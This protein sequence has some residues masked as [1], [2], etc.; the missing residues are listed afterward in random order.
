MQHA[1]SVS[2]VRARTSL[3]IWAANPAVALDLDQTL[4]DS[5]SRVRYKTGSDGSARLSPAA[6]LAIRSR[7]RWRSRISA[8][9]HDRQ[10]P[11][12]TAHVNTHACPQCSR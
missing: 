3:G 4:A 5:P 9:R 2:H 6:S 7:C 1:D 10:A 12:G 8:R 11:T